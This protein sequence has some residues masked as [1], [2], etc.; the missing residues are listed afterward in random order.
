[1]DSPRDHPT[2]VEVLGAFVRRRASP[3]T[4]KPIAA[5]RPSNSPETAQTPTARPAVSDSKPEPSPDVKAALTVLG[6][7]PQRKGLRRGDLSG[8]SLVGAGLWATNLSRASLFGA[9]LSNAWLRLAVLTGAQLK[10]ANLSGA[11]LW[12]AD[13]SGANLQNAD[14]SGAQLQGANLSGAELQE[15]KLTR[16][17]LQEARFPRAQLEGADL[18]G[19]EL[20]GA[21]LS[22]ADGLTQAQVDSSMG[23]AMTQLPRELQRPSA[24]DGDGT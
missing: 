18:S 14:L 15:A 8:A 21:D 16:A 9:D 7:L 22:R 1:M 11:V 17:K 5:E 12:V 3:H 24:W 2:V 20:Q 6:R 10:G 23:D 4:D 13:L 19:A